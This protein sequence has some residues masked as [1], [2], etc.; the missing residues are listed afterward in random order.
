MKLRVAKPW[1]NATHTFH[2]IGTV[3]VNKAI[4]IATDTVC[5]NGAFHFIDSVLIRPNAG[6]SGD[7]ASPLR[8]A[9]S[10]IVDALALPE[11]DV[12]AEERG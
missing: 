3:N 4:V 8:I 9:L 6:T 2:A 5:D 12:D 1:K 10:R 11:F 7:N